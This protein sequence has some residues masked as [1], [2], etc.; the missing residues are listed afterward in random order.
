[1]PLA[2]TLASQDIYD[3]FLGNFEE[4][5]TFFHGHTY[6]GNPLACAVAKKNIELF[7]QPGF[8]DQL[9]TKQNVLSSLLETMRQN[10]HVGDIRQLGLM[11]GIELVQDIKSKFPYAPKLR[12]GHK[13]TL[14]CRNRG[15]IIRPLSDTLVLMPLLS[16]SETELSFLV[17]VVHESLSIALS[18]C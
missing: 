14:E 6:T 9:Q 8:F 15:V 11:V 18:N 13:G 4:F 7:Q 2:A 12:M 5:K 1:M 10:P 3:A 16:I 17:S